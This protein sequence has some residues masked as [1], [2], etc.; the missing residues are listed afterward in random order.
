MQSENK[1]LFN[2]AVKKMPVI[3]ILRDIPLGQEKECV[4]TSVT[5]GLTLIE[6]TMNTK[7][8]I[9]I[10]KALKE[11]AKGTELVVGAG[12]VR[13]LEELNLALDA[14]AGFIVSPTT[15]PEIIEKGNS[16]GIPMIPGALTPTEIEIAYRAGATCVKV[17]PVDALGG[18]SYIK[19]LRG[20]FRDIPL[21]ACGGVHTENAKTYLD[22]SANLLAFGGSIFKPSLM[23]AGEW[24]EIGKNLKEFLIATG[25]A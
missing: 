1:F 25:C 11:A 23:N 17:F 9:E 19:S 3:G 7:N 12:T 2:K 8:A 6:V 15:I 18:P 22:A 10:L 5:Q 16:L 4:R 24:D 13:T 20:P 21:L 14:G